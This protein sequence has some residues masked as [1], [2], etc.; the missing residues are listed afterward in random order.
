LTAFVVDASVGFKWC[1]PAGSEPLTSQ[2]DELMRAFVSG[3]I[4]LLVPDLFWLDIGNALWK[5]FRRRQASLATCSSAFASLRDLEVTT[6]PSADLVQNA[7][8]IASAYGRTVYDS[9][10]VAL[11]EE[12]AA[13]LITADERL[14]I[15][16]GAYFPVKWLGSFHL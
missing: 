4:D 13:N 1:L 7:L 3:E 6:H 11:A 9:V 10:Y 5:L 8:R 15:S 16:L 2:A 14:A 12:S